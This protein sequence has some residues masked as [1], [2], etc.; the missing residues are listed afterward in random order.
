MMQPDLARAIE[1]AHTADIRD[2]AKHLGAKLRKAGNERIG[3]C[4]KC[5]GRDR[6]SVNS[7][8][9]IFNCRGCRTGGD[10]IDLVRL[11]HDR[12][13]IGA[14]AFLTGEDIRARPA[15]KPVPAVATSETRTSLTLAQ[16]AS[17]LGGEIAGD[18]VLAP[19][20]GRARQDRGLTVVLNHAAP[21]GFA[22]FSSETTDFKAL[23]VYLEGRLKAAAAQRASLP[24]RGPPSTGD[25]DPAAEAAKARRIWRPRKPI[26][27]GD[28]AWRYLRVAR[29]YDG[30]IP[31]TLGF[32]P[33][34]NG[35]PPCMIAAFGMA[36]EPEPGL[37]AIA[38]EAVRAVHL[39]QLLPDGSDRT[40]KITVGQGAI[41][42]P[43]V[44]APA[45][46]LLGLAIT[47][48]IEDAL[49]VHAA[50]G[51]GAWAAGSAGRMPALA[52][53]I[54]SN[55]ECVSVFGHRDP[56]GERGARELAARLVDRG[57]ETILKFLEAEQAP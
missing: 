28:P 41:G 13:F 5:G 9:Q 2:V 44:L 31:A 27:E 4:P 56:A 30:Q 11:V 29:G 43:I 55:V 25:A 35:Y 57:V 39:T 48:G 40:Q 8:K 19:L 49:S 6:F 38:D 10:V 46:D 33:A 32:L 53:T 34:E 23:R 21:D 7:G 52:D 51:L 16:I 26:I 18:R 20:P 17:V 37:V 36:D 14:V 12:D 47:E 54:P 22:V 3:P 45:N 42:A 24:D 1:Q 50:T 15:Q